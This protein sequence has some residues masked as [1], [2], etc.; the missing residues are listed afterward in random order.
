MKYLK[1]S[2]GFVVV[3]GLAGCE[4]MPTSLEYTSKKAPP[5]S[6]YLAARQGNICR[7]T[8]YPPEVVSMVSKFSRG[9]D[10]LTV[11]NYELLGKTWGAYM[12][13]EAQ[14]NSN[15]NNEEVPIFSCFLAGDKLSDRG[16]SFD[17]FGIH[18]D[19]KKA[20]QTGFREGYGERNSDLVLGVNLNQAARL[21]SRDSAVRLI[22]VYREKV[23]SDVLSSHRFNNEWE[24]IMDETL[25]TFEEITAEGSPAESRAFL[26]SFPEEYEK[27]LTALTRCLEGKEICDLRPDREKKKEEYMIEKETVYQMLAEGFTSES[28]TKKVLRRPMNYDVM[29]VHIHDTDRIENTYFKY[30]KSKKRNQSDELMLSDSNIVNT[31]LKGDGLVEQINKISWLFVGQEMGRKFNH[32]LIS[33]Q[34][35]I[36]W[37][38]RARSIM[39]SKSGDNYYN[40]SI[41]LLRKGFQQGYG[42]GGENEWARIK[43]ETGLKI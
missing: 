7:L 24:Q 6:G 20:F 9:K 17:Y 38:K 40:T 3:V 19:M 28:E 32:N 22:D 5:S 16:T 36:E 13:E 26:T 15:I 25:G 14:R 1:I 4:S 18:R 39:E 29:T 23:I 21:K 33:R 30:S 35:L 27:E 43:D 31:I 10:K 34:E 11:E 41:R 42:A 2:I 12:S 8:G 37:I